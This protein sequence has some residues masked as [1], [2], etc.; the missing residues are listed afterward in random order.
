MPLP[1]NILKLVRRAWITDE[2]SKQVSSDIYRILYRY[3]IAIWFQ[4][5]I[6]IRFAK[7]NQVRFLHPTE[8]EI[9]LY[10]FKRPEPLD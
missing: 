9:I 7:G 8:H 2:T 1:T 10:N 3:D 6:D 5:G 4:Y